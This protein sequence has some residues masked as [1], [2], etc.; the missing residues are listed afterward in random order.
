MPYL[1]DVN[2]GASSEPLHS[3]NLKIKTVDAGEAESN[4]LSFFVNVVFNDGT[5][6]Y[7]P[8]NHQ[9]SL[10]NLFGGCVSPMPDEGDEKTFPLPVP[11]DLQGKLSLSAI[12]LMDAERFDRNQ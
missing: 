8:L 9:I 1:L 2:P 3:L 11:P 12:N 10:C 5:R 6:L 4:T 7:E